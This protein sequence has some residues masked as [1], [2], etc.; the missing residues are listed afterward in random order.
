MQLERVHRASECGRALFAGECGELVIVA[1][2]LR[3]SLAPVSDCGLW[4]G[5]R[6]EI[7][8]ITSRLS[9]HLW[10]HWMQWK[11]QSGSSALSVRLV[12][13][14]CSAGQI[15]VCGNVRAKR[16]ESVGAQPS[17]RAFVG[18]L[19][20]K[21]VAQRKQEQATQHCAPQCRLFPLFLHAR[22]TARVKNRIT[23]LRSVAQ[24]SV[25]LFLANSARAPPGRKLGV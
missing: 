25:T 3:S 23:F 20:G 8:Q 2:E 14:S 15:T 22:G 18:P 10:A 24:K 1:A 19:L 4:I 17:G 12:L 5:R 6:M 9:W 11:L 16:R 7:G 21:S 13:G